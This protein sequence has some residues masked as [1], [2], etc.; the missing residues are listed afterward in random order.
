MA[1]FFA[2][3]D[4]GPAAKVKQSTTVCDEKLIEAFA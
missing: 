3:H 1:M 2:E 4:S